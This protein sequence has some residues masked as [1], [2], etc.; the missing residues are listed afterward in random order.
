MSEE[1]HHKVNPD[2]YIEFEEE[3]FKKSGGGGGSKKE[4]SKKGKKTLKEIKREQ[5][6]ATK[7]KN[8]EG[9]LGN[10]RKVV[11]KISKEDNLVLNY[12]DWVND[13]LTTSERPLLKEEE[14]V[15]ETAKSSG[16]GGQNVNKRET[17]VIITHRP[18]NIRVENSETRSQETNRAKAE[19][20]LEE[21]LQKHINDWE[22]Y[23]LDRELTK[24]TLREL[25]SF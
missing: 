11:S 17:K 10:I 20:K 24:T 12:I 23:L 2:D 25:I 15:L 3:F 19:Q 16:A 22:T 21:K 14:V 1:K 18:T 4:D 13:V 7:K 8:K 6:Q 5:S 9:A